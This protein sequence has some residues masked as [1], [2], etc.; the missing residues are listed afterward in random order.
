MSSES[1][2]SSVPT[3]SSSCTGCSLVDRR[4]FLSTASLLSVGALLA[5]CGDGVFDGPSAVAE[6]LRNPISVDLENY[7]ALRQI[8]GRAVL[9]PTGSAPM[10]VETIGTQRYRAFSLECP[11]K[12]TVLTY[13]DVAFQCP[14]HGARFSRDGNWIGGQETSD[15]LPIAVASASND[16]ILVGGV[17]LPP[18]PPAVVVSSGSASFSAAIGGGT[19]A[20]QSINITNGGGGALA[21]LAVGLTYATGQ[22]SG[23][24]VAALT[25]VAA[26]A[27]LTLSVTRGSLAVG[28]YSATVQV[29]APGTSNVAQSISATLVVT[30]A[31]SS[32]AL[33]LSSATVSLSAGTG[34]SPTAQS[35][36]V[37]NSGGGTIGALAIAITYGAGASAWLSTSSLNGAS[38]PS[39]LT[40]RPITTALAVG[41]YTATISVSGAGVSARTLTV[42]VDIAPSGLAVTIAAWPDL[43]NIGG[44]AGS[45]GTI[46]FNGVAVV[47]TSATSF[48]ALSL[49]CPHESYLVGVVNGQSFRCPR[50]GALYA[51]NGV[52]QQ[53]SPIK[54][55]N[56]SPLTVTY[57]PGASVLYVT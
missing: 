11:H 46:N 54:A 49:R 36:Q 15:L 25:A 8:G 5:A 27:T 50:H 6:I 42:S 57:V 31:S 55:G 35:V 12:G 20:P 44:V 30:D 22:S 17:V 32:P 29:S 1:S 43:A 3:P 21:G 48:A 45:V 52:V 38:T 34:S 40:V 51:A 26:P 9:T 47:R 28:T 56:L 41:T 4:S 37:I 53:N 2:E 33:Q 18:V 10:I 24:L 39:T 19:S 16:S 7:P 23:W 13:D 14:N